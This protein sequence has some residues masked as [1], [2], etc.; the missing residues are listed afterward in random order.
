MP[1]PTIAINAAMPTRARAERGRAKIKRNT[2]MTSRRRTPTQRGWA[3]GA[4]PS[5]GQVGEVSRGNGCRRLGYAPARV[6]DL[7]SQPPAY[8]FHGFRR[9]RRIVDPSGTF[10]NR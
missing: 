6:I 10:G 9:T 4:G 1:G 2:S 3:A 8:G 7:S 5:E